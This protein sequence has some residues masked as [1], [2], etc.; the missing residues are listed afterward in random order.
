MCLLIIPI[1]FVVFW[2][3]IF[4]NWIVVVAAGLGDASYGDV[5]LFWELEQFGFSI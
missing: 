5:I 4:G 3:I 2:F 1:I